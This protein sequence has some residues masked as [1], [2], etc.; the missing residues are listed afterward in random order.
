MANKLAMLLFAPMSV[1]STRLWATK[2]KKGYY[3]NYF[4]TKVQYCFCRV[5]FDGVLYYQMPKQMPKRMNRKIQQ[6]GLIQE[7][8]KIEKKV[9]CNIT[10]LKKKNKNRNYI[11]LITNTLRYCDESTIIMYLGVYFNEYNLDLC[12][13]L[14]KVLSIDRFKLGIS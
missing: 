9:W 6:A 11:Y 4:S 13:Y 5:L 12:L 3:L 8:N 2:M 1:V 10:V 14:I 7:N